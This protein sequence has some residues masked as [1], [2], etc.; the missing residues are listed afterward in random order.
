MLSVVMLSF[1]MLSVVMLNVVMLSVVMLPNSSWFWQN[2]TTRVGQCKVTS[3]GRQT[4]LI[5][6]GLD[7]NM[8]ILVG[9]Q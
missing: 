6:L 2:L 8:L 5:V 4:S 1:V 7:D 9:L 3:L